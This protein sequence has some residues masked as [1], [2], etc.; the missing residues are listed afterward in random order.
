MEA[1]AGQDR[2]GGK[3]KK[4]MGPE[5]TAR[6]MARGEADVQRQDETTL[7]LESDSPSKAALDYLSSIK[8]EYSD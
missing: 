8:G 6:V 5:I 7:P 4:G 2:A 3:K 1:E